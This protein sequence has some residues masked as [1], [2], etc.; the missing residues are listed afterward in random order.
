VASGQRGGG[1]RG[2]REARPC[3]CGDVER[4]EAERGNIASSSSV[5]ASN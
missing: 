5:E 2:E 4:R 1:G 3:G